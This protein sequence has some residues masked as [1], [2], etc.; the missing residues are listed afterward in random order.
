MKTSE[1]NKMLPKKEMMAKVNS[2]FHEWAKKYRA[3]CRKKMPY[4]SVVG[5]KVS[6]INDQIG[7][8][9]KYL[10]F[11]LLDGNDQNNLKRIKRFLSMQSAQNYKK[12]LEIHFL[13]DSPVEVYVFVDSLND[14]D[15][16]DTHS[17]T[18]FDTMLA[19]R[20]DNKKWTAKSAKTFVETVRNDLEFD[21]CQALLNYSFDRI[22]LEINCRIK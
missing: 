2:L 21:G 13:G 6:I 7:F 18:Y 3:E 9:G 12:R 10:A 16:A 20:E 11:M 1:K 17:I 22:N 15:I 5:E 19:F 8:I 14:I 4:T